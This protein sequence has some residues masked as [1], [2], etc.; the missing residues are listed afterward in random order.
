VPVSWDILESALLVDLETLKDG[1]EEFAAQG[2][3][4]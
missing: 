4:D 2:K 3:K 1:G